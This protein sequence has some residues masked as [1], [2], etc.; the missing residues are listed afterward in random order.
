MQIKFISLLRRGVAG[1]ALAV[2]GGGS[3]SLAVAAQT[4]PGSFVESE[5]APLADP[6]AE[7]PSTV[8]VTI[9]V[10]S[11]VRNLLNAGFT[12]ERHLR[13]AFATTLICRATDVPFVHNLPDEIEAREVGSSVSAE[14]IAVSTAS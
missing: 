11:G 2:I 12:V 5:V 14:G 4:S 3:G 6:N 9:T 8:D 13:E 10:S 1:L 7:S